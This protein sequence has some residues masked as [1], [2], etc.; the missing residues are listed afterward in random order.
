MVKRN[1]IT[2][3]ICLGIACISAFTQVPQFVA[4]IDVGYATFKMGGL[5]THQE[6]MKD[7]Q[8]VDAEIV[9]KF[10]GYLSYGM[11]F[12]VISKRI[13]Y[14]AIHGRTS[15]AG[16]IAYSDYSGSLY[17]NQLV[18]MS[19]TGSRIAVN[20]RPEAK[21]I[22]FYLGIQALVYSNKI[23]YHSEQKIADQ[24]PSTNT[25]K[26]V[27][28]NLGLGPFFEAQKVAGNFLFK[29]Q[30]GCEADFAGGLTATDDRSKLKNNLGNKVR[31]DGTGF[32]MSGGVSYF[33]RK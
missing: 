33:I 30:A 2:T 7:A 28:I 16:R 22:R 1:I 11:N 14:G 29:V 32:R 15:T 24:S 23:T 26:F 18:R 21:S 13:L 19:Y 12:T 5:K 25:R 31:A 4:G 6:D 20:L 9:D 8:A 27:S 3:V 10:P 17:I